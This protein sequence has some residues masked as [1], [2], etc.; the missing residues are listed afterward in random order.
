MRAA[1]T[2]VAAKCTTTSTAGGICSRT[3]TQVSSGRGTIVMRAKRRKKTG[4]RG[5][6]RMRSR[7]IDR[8]PMRNKRIASTRSRP[9]PPSPKGGEE[10]RAIPPSERR[11]AHRQK[12]RTRAGFQKAW[13]R[14]KIPTIPCPPPL[15]RTPPNLHRVWTAARCSMRRI[16]RSIIFRAR[17][18]PIPCALTARGW[19]PLWSHHCC[20][21]PRQQ[22]PRAT[23]S[24]TADSPPCC[25]PSRKNCKRR[26]WS[27]PW[28]CC[29]GRK[30][31]RSKWGNCG[32]KSSGASTA[33]SR[34][35][36]TAS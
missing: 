12:R 33:T 26:S 27:M 19:I 10:G 9:R 22:R 23:R 20:Q 31:S 28:A 15:F 29:K 1:N 11:A 25:T 6:R 34:S 21:P 35:A 4:S 17:T 32:R 7:R 2:V 36:I 24:I 14:R 3:R 16:A 30:R 8:L 18:S 5:K 13:S